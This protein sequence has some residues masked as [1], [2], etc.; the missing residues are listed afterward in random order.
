MEITE[1]NETTVRSLK[2]L[3]THKIQPEN[4]NYI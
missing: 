4:S 2:F 1:T 3:S